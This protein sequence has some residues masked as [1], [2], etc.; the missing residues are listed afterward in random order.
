MKE[1]YFPAMKI[2]EYAHVETGSFDKEKRHTDFVQTEKRYL[3]FEHL[4]QKRL[5]N[6]VYMMR[7][8]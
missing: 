3:C 7:I 8:F 2:D 6:E 5:N 1:S 4:A